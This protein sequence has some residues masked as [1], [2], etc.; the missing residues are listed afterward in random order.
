MSDR[1]TTL[2]KHSAIIFSR[3]QKLI[4]Q[5][6]GF[7]VFKILSKVTIYPNPQLGHQNMK[8]KESSTA[9]MSNNYR[10]RWMPSLGSFFRFD[11]VKIWDSLS[12][13]ML[14]GPSGYRGPIK[15]YRWS[16]PVLWRGVCNKES[17]NRTF[18][19]PFLPLAA[20]DITNSQIVNQPLRVEPSN[21][22][23]C[24]TPDLEYSN[25][26]L[27]DEIGSPDSNMP[28]KVNIERGKSRF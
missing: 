20:G 24:S 12:I 9:I 6:L 22:H 13:L 10:C 25:N 28:L 17:F 18:S 14:S 7:I 23:V 1:N 21:P 15:G 11:H 19:G 16:Y 8:S 3:I 5:P 2:T 26:L 27:D 4:V